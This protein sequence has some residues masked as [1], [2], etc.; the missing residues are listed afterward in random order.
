VLGAAGTVAITDEDI[1]KS[2]AARRPLAIAKGSPVM[3][4][5]SGAIV[6][7]DPMLKSLAA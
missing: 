1:R 2:F 5:Q 7:D 3:L 6:P 4:V